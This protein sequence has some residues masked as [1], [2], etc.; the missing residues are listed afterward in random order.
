MLLRRTVLAAAL[1][2]LAIHAQAPTTAPPAPPPGLDQ[3]DRADLRAHVETLAA[4]GMRGRL[5]ATPEQERAADY[6]AELFTALGLEPIGD[7]VDGKRGFRQLYPVARTGLGEGA[8][9]AVGESRLGSGF[10]V[11]P[12]RR[13]ESVQAAGPLVLLEPGARALPLL[14]GKVP[15]LCI[16]T[17]TGKGRDINQQ[18]GFA[19]PALQRLAPVVRN[20]QK[21]GAGV[22]LV[23]LFDDDAALANVLAYMSIAPGKPMVRPRGELRAIVGGDQMGGL[24]G[25]LGGRLPVVFLSAATTKAVL[26]GGGVDVAAMRTFVDQDGP[27]PALVG[28]VRVGVDLPLHREDAE[29]CNVVAVLRGADEGLREEA[30]VFSAHMDHVGSRLDGD[31]FNGADDNASGTAGLLEIAQAFAR[32]EPRPKRSVIFLSVSGE[33]LGLW[34]SAWYAENPTWPLEKLVGNVNTDMIGRGGPDAAL[35]QVM[36]TPSHEHSQ[37]SSMARTAAE[38]AA[39]IGIDVL[40]DDKFFERSDHYNFVKKG[41]PAVFFCCAGEHADYHQVSDHAD[42]LDDQQMEKTARLAYWVGRA[43]ADASER[44]TILGRRSDWFGEAKSR[45]R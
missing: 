4:D 41:I 33:E 29:A 6:I 20:V 12:T 31:A 22:L 36:L 43:V 24:G 11:I 21:A 30:V 26:A 28:E 19:F 9:L 8:H 39:T 32:T 7:E 23:G 2:P 45:R 34:G 1:L 13:E 16:K 35:G 18:F 14:D 38:A 3:I 10:A 44:P 27:A 17:L 15:L 5:T 40:A 37:Y 25:M 42:L